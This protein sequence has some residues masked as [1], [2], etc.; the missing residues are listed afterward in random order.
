VVGREI[1]TV[2]GALT[3]RCFWQFGGP[4]ATQGRG[5]YAEFVFPI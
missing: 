4:F 1:T 2:Q 3:I 5:L